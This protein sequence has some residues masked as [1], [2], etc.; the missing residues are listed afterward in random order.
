MYI[1]QYSFYKWQ[2]VQV[3]PGPEISGKVQVIAQ[4]MQMILY[5]FHWQ[6]WFTIHVNNC[7]SYVTCAFSASQE[8]WSTTTLASNTPSGRIS[9]RL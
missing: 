8:V 3:M 4:V 5:S 6:C 2:V 9:T 1:E 7:L